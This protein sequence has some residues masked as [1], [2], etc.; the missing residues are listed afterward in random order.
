MNNFIFSNIKKPIHGP[1]RMQESI[2]PSEYRYP[3]IPQDKAYIAYIIQA[4]YIIQ[5]SMYWTEKRDQWAAQ[6][7][8]DPRTDQNIGMQVP[9]RIQG[10]IDRSEIQGSVYSSENRDAWTGKNKRIHGSVKKYRS[11]DRSGIL[12]FMNR[13]EYRSLYFDRSV[14]PNILTGPWIPI[15][16]TGP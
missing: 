7:C 5:G 1:V 8:R 11:T 10:S 4:L 13:S 9:V 2:E 15:Y 12:I 6:K 3:W 14:D 16:L